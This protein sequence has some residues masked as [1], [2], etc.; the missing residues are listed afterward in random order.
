MA[1]DVCF[2]TNYVC[3]VIVELILVFYVFGLYMF[4][5]YMCW[6]Y[7]LICCLFLNFLSGV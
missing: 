2:K 5:L 6:E 7:L 3:S 1:V 4:I